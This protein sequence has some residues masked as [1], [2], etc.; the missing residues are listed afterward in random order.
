METKIHEALGDVLDFDA[1][2]LFPFA[3]IKDALVRDATGFA[4]VENREMPAE[5]CGDVVCVEDR[6]RRGI[7]EGV[8]AHHGDIHPR[9]DQNAGAAEI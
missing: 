2:A 5:S 8:G 3:Q 7:A 9:N 6:D 1:G 4:F